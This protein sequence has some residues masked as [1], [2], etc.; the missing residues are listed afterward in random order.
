MRALGWLAI[1]A[2]LC[3]LA[4]S[5]E[6]AE[7]ETIEQLQRDMTAGHVSSEALVKHYLARI[8]TLDRHG[9]ALH[10]VLEFNS[11]AIAQARALDL[12]R[13]EPRVRG[14]LHCMPLLIKDNIET[15]DHIPTTAGSLA[16]TANFSSADAA[17]V[18]A[19]RAA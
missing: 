3:N 10:A 15:R 1:F 12:E 13:H 2:G 11:D 5:I 9:P 7:F 17:V 16:L 4:W 8:E 6:P 18:A 19:L 14:P